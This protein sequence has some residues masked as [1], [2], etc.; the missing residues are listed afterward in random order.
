M[1]DNVFPSTEFESAAPVVPV[2]SLD[3]LIVK[4]I[5][6]GAT[7]RLSLPA[8]KEVLASE[9]GEG[10]FVY[11]D[12]EQVVDHA[13]QIHVDGG[14]QAMV[15]IK[16]S[17]APDTYAYP[18]DLPD[19]A[20]AELQDDGS[21]DIVSTEGEL[22]GRFNAPWAKDALG[23]PV[24]T[25]YTLEDGAIVQHVDLSQVSAFPV[26][27]DPDG[28]IGWARCGTAIALFAAENATVF[29]KLRKLGGAKK[30]VKALKRL[31]NKDERKM[32]LY[33]LAGDITGL[34]RLSACL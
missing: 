4:D 25:F 5:E 24:P 7:L 3:P 29:G 6:T 30:Y 18:L 13:L 32:V 21:I 10:L 14:F 15:V 34:D 22:I 12:A 16:D 1:R 26:V 8:D 2:T 19:G 17:S 20:S 31:K 28:W 11:A 9:V 27:A 33:K 23:R